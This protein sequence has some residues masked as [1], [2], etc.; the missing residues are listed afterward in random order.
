MKLIFA[1][2]AQRDL[3]DIIAYY[4]FDDLT[5]AETVARAITDAARLLTD[6]PGLGHSG[7]LAG[8]REYSISRLPYIIVYTANAD[9]VTVLAVFHASRNLPRALAERQRELDP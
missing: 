5:A 7:R 1:R 2:A 3:A 4:G 8:T 9:T 6:F